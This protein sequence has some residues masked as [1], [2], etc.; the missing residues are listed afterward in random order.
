[1]VATFELNQ[2]ESVDETAYLP[3]TEANRAVLQDSIHASEEYS[4]SVDEFDAFSKALLTDSPV[5]V[6]AYKRPVYQ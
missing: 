1:M 4:F 6:E 3:S 5:D 2:S